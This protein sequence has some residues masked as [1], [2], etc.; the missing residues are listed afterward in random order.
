VPRNS[1]QECRRPHRETS[2]TQPGA[3]AIAVKNKSEGSA[4]A[5]FA[6]VSQ[7]SL[8]S[9]HLLT[10][11]VRAYVEGP[12]GQGDPAREEPWAPHG[13]R[14]GRGGRGRRIG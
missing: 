5:A 3:V 4:G 13:V 11:P 9:V 12:V 6:N 2:G 1:L 7:A 10:P 8:K 14:L